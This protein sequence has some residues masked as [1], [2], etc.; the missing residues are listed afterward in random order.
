M[1]Q[2]LHDAPPTLGYAKNY[3]VQDNYGLAGFK[4][5]TDLKFTYDHLKVG[6]IEKNV[7]YECVR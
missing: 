4:K 1:K 6:K 7:E 3:H 5:A 2:L